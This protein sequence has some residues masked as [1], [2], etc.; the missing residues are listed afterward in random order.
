MISMTK[1][2]YEC[3]TAAKMA[4]AMEQ[5]ENKEYLLERQTV[6]DKKAK[7]Y[8]W[9][10]QIADLQNRMQMATDPKYIKRCNEIV[11]D[12]RFSIARA[13]EYIKSQMR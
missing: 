8:A 10:E 6:S 1:R 11:A 2:I 4:V 3:A 12:L 13:Q 7:I 9:E 5:K